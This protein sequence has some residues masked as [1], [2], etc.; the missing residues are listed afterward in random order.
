M[1]AKEELLVL[2]VVA[3]ALLV[4]WIALRRKRQGGA[5]GHDGSSGADYAGGD[6][7]GNGWFGGHGHSAGDHGG[8]SG[9]A[10]G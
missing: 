7:S 3:G 4:G 5:S 2:I 10:G 9:D 1:P 6:A 8:A